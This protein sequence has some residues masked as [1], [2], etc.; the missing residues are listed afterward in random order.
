M[1]DGLFVMGAHV[2]QETDVGLVR[3]GQRPVVADHPAQCA[4]QQ[5]DRHGDDAEVELALP[6]WPNLDIDLDIG[7]GIVRWRSDL[8]ELIHVVQLARSPTVETVARTYYRVAIRRH[9]GGRDAT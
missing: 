3:I 5:S 6:P 9:Q 2:L 1:L 7:T 8:L 4:A